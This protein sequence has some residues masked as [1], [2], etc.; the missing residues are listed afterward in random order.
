MLPYFLETAAY[1]LYTTL[2]LTSRGDWC[3]NQTH[4]QAAFVWAKQPQGRAQETEN[5]K[6][7]KS[8]GE[9]IPEQ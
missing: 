4:L 9:H 8:C 2:T 1:F 6:V 3:I 5:S 7:T